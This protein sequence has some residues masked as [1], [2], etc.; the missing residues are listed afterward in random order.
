MEL[1]GLALRPQE[2]PPQGRLRGGVAGGGGEYGAPRPERQRFSEYESETHHGQG[3]RAA[4]TPGVNR[5]Y[6][7][8]TGVATLP[9]LERPGYSHAAATRRTAA[10]RRRTY[11]LSRHR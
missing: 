2:K 11:G 3:G 9:G 8:S 5:R 4:G 10:D 7:T 1:Q 6:A